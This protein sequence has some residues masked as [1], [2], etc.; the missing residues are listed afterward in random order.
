MQ[1]TLNPWLRL[2]E[3]YFADL[4]PIYEREDCYVEF[5]RN[6]MLQADS[7]ARTENYV[8]QLTN[9]QCSINDINRWENRPL[10][11]ASYGDVRFM[12]V[13]LAPM[14]KEYVDSYMAKQKAEALKNASGEIENE[15][16]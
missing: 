13:N 16:G 2:I 10:V 11:D 12:P 4:L 5:D 7:T 9:G 15:E 14:T 3:Q 1:C 6:A 8:R